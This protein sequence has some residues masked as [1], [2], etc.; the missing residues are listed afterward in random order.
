[1]EV[2]FRTDDHATWYADL[3][4]LCGDPCSSGGE[5]YELIICDHKD[6]SSVKKA[7]EMLHKEIMNMVLRKF[8]AEKS[9][10]SQQG[11]RSG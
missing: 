4:R 1:M 6:Y 2:D 7:G 8:S 9:M 10:G 5:W 3:L 11:S